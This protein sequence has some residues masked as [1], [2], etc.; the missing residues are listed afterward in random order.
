MSLLLAV[1]RSYSGKYVYLIFLQFQI[2][3]FYN[4]WVFSSALFALQKQWVIEVF[5]F[6]LS[7]YVKNIYQAS[8]NNC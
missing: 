2:L 8:F 3:K 4:N 5:F 6:K 7:Y 1:T